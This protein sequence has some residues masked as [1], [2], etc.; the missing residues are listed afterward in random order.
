MLKHTIF[1]LS[2]LINQMATDTLHK[3][4]CQKQHLMN[5]FLVKES[6]ARKTV[7]ENFT[8][9]KLTHASQY[10]SYETKNCCNRLH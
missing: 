8:P 6:V 2:F 1:F 5:K 10:A 7:R 4:E 9:V 3:N